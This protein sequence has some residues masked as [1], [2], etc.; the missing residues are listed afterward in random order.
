M[1]NEIW[2]SSKIARMEGCSNKG[3]LNFEFNY[4]SFLFLQDFLL[5]D[6]TTQPLLYEYYRDAIEN[7]P[8]FPEVIPQHNILIICGT[9]DK[10]L[11]RESIDKYAGE[12]FQ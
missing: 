3:T 4:N 8:P 10:N 2:N 1:E 9:K 5:D 12:L 11:P 6:G 7:H